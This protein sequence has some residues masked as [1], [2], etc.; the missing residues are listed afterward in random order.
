MSLFFYDCSESSS[1]R[2]Y[3]SKAKAS[4]L[5]T[6][7]S[8]QSDVAQSRTHRQQQQQQQTLPR[9]PHQQPGRQQSQFAIGMERASNYACTQDPASM[10][11]QD[12]FAPE[13]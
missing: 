3:Y 2:S 8:I 1:N 5:P 6:A 10:P 13:V 7:A 9:L 12:L 4:D 11:D